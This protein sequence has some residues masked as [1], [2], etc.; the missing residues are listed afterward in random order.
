ML[1]FKT[2]D[3]PF[4]KAFL[5]QDRLCVVLGQVRFRAS[6]SWE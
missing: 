6:D 4:W 2:A 1:S 3:T 5:L